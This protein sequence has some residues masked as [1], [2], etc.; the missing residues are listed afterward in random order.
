MDQG[1]FLNL[2]FSLEKVSHKSLMLGKK[3]PWEILD[4]LRDYVDSYKDLGKIDSP[5]P[6]GL[7]LINPELISIGKD[8]HIAAGATL[9]GPCIIGPGCQIRSGAFVRAYTVLEEHV[10][11]GHC[12]ECK[13]S[14]FLPYAKA[15]HFNYVGDSIIG[16]NVNLGAGVTCANLRLDHKEISV[17][18]KEGE[19]VKTGRNKLGAIIGD[20]SQIGCQSVINPGIILKKGSLIRPLTSVSCSNIRLFYASEK[21]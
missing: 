9:E 3:F 14:L 18:D 21:K 7:N 19:R 10:T 2:L 8:V 5:L 20:G 11:I 16:C 4:H 6:K 13:E 17:T 15:P 12:T 1:L